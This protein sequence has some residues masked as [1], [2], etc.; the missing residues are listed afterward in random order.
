M[1]MQNLERYS[2]IK[3]GGLKATF[4]DVA[5]LIAVSKED[6]QLLL[7]IVG[8]EIRKKQLEFQ[9]KD[10]SIGHQLKQ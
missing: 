2:E 6:L 4:A 8:E 7:D 5:V 3:E 1:I 9:Q 10:R